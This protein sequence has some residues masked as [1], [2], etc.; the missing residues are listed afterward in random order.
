MENITIKCPNCNRI[1]DLKFIVGQKKITKN[2]F[3]CHVCHQPY[4]KI[5]PRQPSECQPTHHHI[6]RPEITKKELEKLK[7]KKEKIYSGETKNCITCSRQKP[8]EEF[9]LVYRR[10][11]GQ[12]GQSYRINRC[13]AC[14][15]E[16]LKFRNEREKKNVS[17]KLKNLS[18][19]EKEVRKIKRRER[20]KQFQQENPEYCR[21]QKARSAQKGRLSRRIRNRLSE[22]LKGERGASFSKM[23][24]CSSSELRAYIE[25]K[26]LSGMTWDNYGYGYG[27]WVIDHIKPVALFDKST[28]EELAKSCHYSNLQPLWY[29]MNEAKSN[30]YDPD[31]PMGWHGL[32]K[33]LIERGEPTPWLVG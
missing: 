32:D 7:P 29:D 11:G 24:G 13:D 33:F 26:F 5:K 18:L 28:K 2:N 31:H 4:L 21:L 6:R 19:E 1:L 15:L 30:N 9:Y 20:R 25:S 3:T 22:V 16:Y 14:R 27:Q 17:D 12:A 8:I 23:L 10:S